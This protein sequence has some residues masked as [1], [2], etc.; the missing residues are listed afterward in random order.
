MENLPFMKR[1]AFPIVS[2]SQPFKTALI[3]MS[4]TGDWSDG[5]VY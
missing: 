4:N 1:L 3:S 5:R 2:D